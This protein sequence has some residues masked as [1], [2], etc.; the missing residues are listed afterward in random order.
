MGGAV[1]DYTSKASQDAAVSFFERA[2]AIDPELGP[3][4]VGL[5]RTSIE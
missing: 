5:A 4:M 3:P 2:L 1:R